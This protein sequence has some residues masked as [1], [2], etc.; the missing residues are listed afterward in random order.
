MSWWKS[1]AALERWAELHPTHVRIF[2]AAMKYL[3]TLGPAAKLRLYHEVTVA[4]ADEAFFRVSGLSPQDRDVE[5][6][7]ADHRIGRPPHRLRSSPY[8]TIWVWVTIATSLPSSVSSRVCQTWVRRPRCT[9]RGGGDY[10]AALPGAADEIGLALDRGGALGILG[11][12][13]DGRSRA[14]RIRKRHHRAAVNCIVA[15]CRDPGAPASAPPHGPCRLRRRSRPS[16][17]QTASS[18]IGFFPAASCVL[19][20]FLAAISESK[21]G[22]TR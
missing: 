16:I 13:D 5:R 1:L 11:Q 8:S 6:G 18:S 4:R 12:I 15:A 19:P 10:R 2:G 17:P 3:S 22:G 7:V 14:D 9:G 21:D 20:S